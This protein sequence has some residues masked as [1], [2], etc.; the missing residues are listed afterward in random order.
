MRAEP[1]LAREALRSFNT[2][3]QSQTQLTNS[4]FQV[5]KITQQTN[6]KSIPYE[7]ERVAYHPVS[8]IRLVTGLSA[9]DTYIVERPKL[10]VVFQDVDEK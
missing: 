3:N 8:S 1:E 7:T 6:S 2:P 10:A 5:Y 9:C 4:N